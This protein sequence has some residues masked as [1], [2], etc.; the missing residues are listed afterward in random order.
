MISQDPDEVLFNQYITPRQVQDLFRAH[1][2]PSAGSFPLNKPFP[3]LSHNVRCL[4]PKN[5][6]PF[7]F[8]PDPDLI[9]TFRAFVSLPPRIDFFS[10]PVNVVSLYLKPLLTVHSLPRL[11]SNLALSH[12]LTL[13]LSLCFPQGE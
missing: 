6:S 4:F 8:F 5:P 2:Y 12:S 10:L 11:S 1:K 7:S 3:N 13:P 9:F